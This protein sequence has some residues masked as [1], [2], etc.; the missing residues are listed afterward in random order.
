M[1]FE[2]LHISTKKAIYVA[3]CI[4]I[5]SF[6]QKLAELIKR[7]CFLCSNF[8]KLL[9]TGG[10]EKYPHALFTHRELE[11]QEKNIKRI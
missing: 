11:W 5:I 8:F 10:E 9:R 4:Q 6:D 1:Q 3:M 7:Y 2:C